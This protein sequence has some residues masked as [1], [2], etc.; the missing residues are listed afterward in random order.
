LSRVGVDLSAYQCFSHG[1]LYVALSRVRDV[2]HIKVFTFDKDR[3]VRNPVMRAIIDDEELAEA[4]QLGPDPD[5]QDPPMP[6]PPSSP[7]ATGPSDSFVVETPPSITRA[8]PAPDR[9]NFN[10]ANR[11]HLDKIHIVKGDITT[12]R[13]D[14]IVN[15]ANSQL[16]QGGG[17]DK[18]IHEACEPDEK[19]LCKDLELLIMSNSGPFA[20]GSVV[21]TPAYGSLRNNNVSC[22]YF[23]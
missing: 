13:V 15:A 9:L 20:A 4:Q 11:H 14:C 23:A 6:I 18:A 1:Q 7:D 17:V 16:V 2:Q 5:D 12:L 10:N 22:K 3:L 8:L 19:Q 21:K